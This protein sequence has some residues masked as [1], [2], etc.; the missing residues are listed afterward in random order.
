MG[1]SPL[2][3]GC[4]VIMSPKEN[5]DPKEKEKVPPVLPIGPGTLASLRETAGNIVMTSKIAGASY[6]SEPMSAGCK[7][8][9][10]SNDIFDANAKQWVCALAIKEVSRPNTIFVSFKGS[11]QLR[12]FLVTDADILLLKDIPPIVL[13]ATQSFVERVQHDFPGY[14]IV[15]T[16]HSLGG[17]LAN[18]SAIRNKLPS[19]AFDALA[20]RGIQ[21]KYFPRMY[22][23]WFRYQYS[24]K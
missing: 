6:P 2:T 16:G 4:E 10:D 24:I 14:Q 19:I 8:L 5:V 21:E 1:I 23:L 18:I 12:D 3:Y 20:I 13:D 9:L 17:S 11:N 15:F 22:E 7:V